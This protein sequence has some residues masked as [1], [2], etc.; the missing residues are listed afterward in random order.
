MRI[1]VE[2][3]GRVQMPGGSIIMWGH[4]CGVIWIAKNMSYITRVRL[5]TPLPASWAGWCNGQQMLT[6]RMPY[7]NNNGRGT[8]LP[9]Y[10][11]WQPITGRHSHWLSCDYGH[12]IAVNDGIYTG[13]RI[14][15]NWVSTQDIV[16]CYDNDKSAMI[17]VSETAFRAAIP[18]AAAY[19]CTTMHS[20][21]PDSEE[22]R[23]MQQSH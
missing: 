22:F 13:Y 1:C 10:Q 7:D 23:K 18:A 19:F 14:R 20:M 6:Y 4:N 17:A 5:Y 8:D 16:D 9:V 2:R 3:S 11:G 12:R 15:A 21:R